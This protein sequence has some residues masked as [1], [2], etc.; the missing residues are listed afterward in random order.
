[1]SFKFQV[2][3]QSDATRVFLETDHL[4]LEKLGRRRDHG[5]FGFDMSVPILDMPTSRHWPRYRSRT[6]L[7]AARG[8]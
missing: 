3:S 4:K 7:G 5:A 8:G 2:S 6:G 1:M